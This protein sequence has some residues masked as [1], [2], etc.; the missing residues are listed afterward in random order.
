MRQ[1]K[2]NGKT[3]AAFIVDSNSSIHHAYSYH[4]N[5]NFMKLKLISKILLINRNCSV[6]FIKTNTFFYKNHLLSFVHPMKEFTSRIS[7]TDK[8]E[9]VMRPLCRSDR[10]INASYCNTG[11]YQYY[12]QFTVLLFVYCS[13]VLNMREV[14]KLKFRQ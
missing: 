2:L 1:C 3:A 12:N 13:C 11:K 5:A 7:T 10:K 9:S 4:R 6:S 14:M 8:T